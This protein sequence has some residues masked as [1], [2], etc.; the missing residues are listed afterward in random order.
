MLNL[1]IKDGVDVLVAAKARRPSLRVIV[2]TMHAGRE[3]VSR[4]VKGGADNARGTAWRRDSVWPGCSTRA[5]A[6]RFSTTTT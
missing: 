5:S 1:P 4:A 2:L 6:S 3:Y